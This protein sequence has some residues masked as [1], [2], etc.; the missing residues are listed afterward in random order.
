MT[1]YLNHLTING[2][3]NEVDKIASSF[4]WGAPFAALFPLP[5]LE[6]TRHEAVLDQ[7]R[8]YWGTPD[9]AIKPQLHDIIS[10]SATIE[11]MT[12]ESEPDGFFRFIA[13]LHPMLSGS[14]Q[15]HLVG[16]PHIR[17]GIVRIGS[18]KTFTRTYS[19]PKSITKEYA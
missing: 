15:F 17:S 19:R 18:G 3:E 8:K 2:P 5:K 7:R 1:L 11:F 14:C 4:M 6:N 16:H 13:R 12:T 10:N 9:D